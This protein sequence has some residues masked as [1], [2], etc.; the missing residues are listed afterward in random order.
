MKT[1][2]LI[3][4]EEGREAGRGTDEGSGTVGGGKSETG[5]G[6]GE[7]IEGGR[8]RGGGVSMRDE[9]GVIITLHP[10]SRTH[11][12]TPI[13]IGVRTHTPTLC[14]GIPPADKKRAWC[15]RYSC[16]RH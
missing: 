5:G 2:D 7:G 11:S 1:E 8:A 3:G 6:D 14:A 12:N 16:E 13:K 15:G 9:G 4:G 10:P